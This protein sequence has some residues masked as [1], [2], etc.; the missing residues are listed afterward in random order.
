M[1]RDADSSSEYK[2][3]TVIFSSSW[4][5]WNKNNFYKLIGIKLFPVSTSHYHHH[6]LLNF[7]FL[8]MASPKV[9]IGFTKLRRSWIR[10]H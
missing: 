7:M 5:Y 2:I 6:K 8:R 1:R 3:Y 9:E 4:A 10:I